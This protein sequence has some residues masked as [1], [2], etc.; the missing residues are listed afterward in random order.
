MNELLEI[1]KA[2]ALF[3][4]IGGCVIAGMKAVDWA[5]P[6]PEKI[7]KVIVSSDEKTTRI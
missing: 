4:L 2:A 7:I 3:A 6:S 5:T 1:I